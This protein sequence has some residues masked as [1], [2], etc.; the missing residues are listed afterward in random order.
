MGEKK[1][2]Y[3]MDLLNSEIVVKE[4]T[5]FIAEKKILS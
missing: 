2:K 5:F 4:L 3:Q 1:K